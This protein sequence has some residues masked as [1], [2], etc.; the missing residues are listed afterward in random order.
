MKEAI[1]TSDALRHNETDIFVTNNNSVTTS[2]LLG[3][4]VA[5][6]NFACARSAGGGYWSG[7]GAQEEDLC[8]LLPQ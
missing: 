1:D 8:R 7:S 4:G 6:L 5:T 3:D 2:L